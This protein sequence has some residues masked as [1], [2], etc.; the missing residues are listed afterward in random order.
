[1]KTKSPYA[2]GTVLLLSLLLALPADIWALPQGTGQRA[3]EV[4]RVIP[5]VSIARGSQKITAST[6]SV[7][8]W[9]DLVNTQ[10]NG[11]ARIAL[12]DGSVLNVGSESSMLVKEYNA[13]AQQTDLELTYGK[14]RTQAVKIT[15]PDGKFQVHTP[16]GVAGVVGTDFFVAYD[17]VT[18]TMNVLVFEGLVRVCNLAGVCVEVKA[19]QFTNVRTGNNSAPLA[20]VQASLD[21]LTSAT[22]DTEIGGV[23]PV[24]AVQQ[25]HHI[26]KATLVVLGVVAAVPAV[27]VPVASHSTTTTT[28]VRS[29]CPTSATC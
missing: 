28:P 10:V 12:D 22:H 23:S 11:R 26:S 3:G 16:A 20:P 14:L 19:G 5:A 6:R 29:R 13:G 9:Y 24:V 4:S 18:Q 8:Y 17:V 15:K 25:L 21:V 27:V 2:W 1:M 7:V